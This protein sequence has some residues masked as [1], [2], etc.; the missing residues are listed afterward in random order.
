MTGW[1]PVLP[2][3]SL[4]DFRYSSFFDV[5]AIHLFAVKFLELINRKRQHDL[6]DSLAACATGADCSIDNG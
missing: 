6:V 2:P 1:Q 3:E 4:R 5:F